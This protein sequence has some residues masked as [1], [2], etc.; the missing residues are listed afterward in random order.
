VPQSIH[1]LGGYRT[2]GRQPDAAQRL[3]EDAR[4]LIEAGVFL[5]VL[6]MVEP[7]V[8]R[9]ITEEVPVP[10]IGIGSGPDCDGQ[11]L[12]SHD[13]LGLGRGRPPSF[14]K[15]Y[16]HLRQEAAEAI[17]RWLSDVLGGTFPPR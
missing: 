10:T 14:V 8:A 3:R 9:T 12:V 2:Q 7:G 15:E 4:A 1:Q 17:R 13:L 5:I 16:A 6:E 11:V